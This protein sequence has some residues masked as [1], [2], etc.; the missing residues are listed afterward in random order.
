MQVAVLRMKGAELETQTPALPAAEVSEHR[1][2]G[3]G[4]SSGKGRA[5]KT[6]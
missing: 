5:T 1:A 6:S 4:Q 2:V 3:S